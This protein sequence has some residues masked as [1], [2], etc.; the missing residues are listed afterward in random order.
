MYFTIC[1]LSETHLSHYL[2]CVF[3]SVSGRQRRLDLKIK[4]LSILPTSFESEVSIS[5]EVLGVIGLSLCELDETFQS[6]GN[7][8]K[9][10]TICDTSQQKVKK[11]IIKNRHNLFLISSKLVL[12]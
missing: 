2:V 10:I 12:L 9:M 11:K 4:Y 5:N 3:V 6:I 1:F 8:I 7:P